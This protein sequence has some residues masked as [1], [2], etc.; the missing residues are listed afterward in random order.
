MGPLTVLLVGLGLAQAAPLRATLETDEVGP[1][2]TT[3]LALARADGARLPPTTAG[4]VVTGATVVGPPE[5]GGTAGRWLR[6]PVRLDGPLA[7]AVEVDWDGQTATVPLAPPGTVAGTVAGRLVGDTSGRPLRIAV[8]GPLA[9]RAE[10]L[11]LAF[12]EG[13]VLGIEADPDGGRLWVRWRPGPAPFARAVP[14]V[15]GDAAHPGQAPL[16]AVIQLR[17]RPAIPITT[18]PGVQVTA[19]VGGRSYGPF[20][21]GEDGVARVQVEVRPGE[22]VARVLL[23]D[24]DG[25]RN[26]TSLSLAGDARPGLAVVAAGGAP[27]GP[28]APAALVHGVRPDGRPWTGAPPRCAATPG[29]ALVLVP[30]GPGLWRAALGPAATAGPPTRR[31]DCDL[32]MLAQNG[33]ELPTLGNRPHAVGISAAPPEL[34]SAAPRAV[35]RAW[36]ESA[37]GER[38]SAEGLSLRATHGSL[39]ELAST[40]SQLRATLDGRAAVPHGAERVELVLERPPAVGPARELAL[41][42]AVDASGAAVVTALATDAAGRGVAGAP[43]TLAALGAAP[44]DDSRAPVARVPDAS[45]ALRHPLAG[46]PAQV[47]AT[48]PGAPPVRALCVPGLPIQPARAPLTAGLS[49]P[50][51]AGQVREV[52]LTSAPRSLEL[53]PEAKARITLQLIDGGGGPVTGEAV[54]LSASRG[55]VDAPRVR[56]DGTVVATYRPEPRADLGRVVITARSPEGRFATTSTELE[57]VPA[58]SRWWPGVQLG[59]LAGLGGISSPYAALALGRPLDRLDDRLHLRGAVGA[60]RLSATVEETSGQESVDLQLIAIPVSLGADLRADRSRTATWAGA[61]LVLAPTRLQVTYG[62]LDTVQGVQLAP[63]GAELRIGGALGLRTGEL[64]AELSWLFLTAGAADLGWQGPVGGVIASLGY[65]AR[66]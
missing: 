15:V 32:S 37:G 44:S 25:G 43:V 38:L 58:G 12:G 30:L 36:V 61:S 66:L 20:V 9:A 18:R 3:W 21:A 60:Y 26:S 27:G 6:L 13:E 48:V 40:P 47:R 56:P 33:V 41:R 51:V 50:V 14:L 49:L 4:L 34:S 5:G 31:I 46:A 65:R 19:E 16:T 54:E 64:T 2:D 28:V 29:D 17:A 53:G 52:F 63:P 23:E 57:L 59:W 22:Q 10:D 1:G 8:E 11:R 7:P 55:S 35:L 42:C 24:A 62:A 45:G 39:V